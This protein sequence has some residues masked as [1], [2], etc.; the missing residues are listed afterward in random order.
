VP[1]SKED[2]GPR[3]RG[4]IVHENKVFPLKSDAGEP[5]TWQR[6]EVAKAAG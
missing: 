5:T 1:S 2:L 6:N 3:I 4:R